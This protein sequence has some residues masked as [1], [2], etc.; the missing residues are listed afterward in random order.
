MLFYLCNFSPNATAYAHVNVALQFDENMY[1]ALASFGFT[2]VFAA[3]SLFAGAV[4][5]NHDR[6][7]LVGVACLGW[8]VATGLQSTATQFYQL[9]ILRSL[10]GAFQAFF[11]PCA[12]TLLA[13]LFP[14]RRLGAVNGVFSSAIYLGGSL[15][16]ISILL[17]QAL[18]WRSTLQIIAF[19]S[20]LVALLC[21]AA[22]PEPRY[23]IPPYS[24][25]SLCA[26]GV[27]ALSSLQV[28]LRTYE[29][30]LL[31]AA[32][33]FRWCAGYAIIV[34]KAPFVFA[35]FAGRD[36][37]FASS[38]AVVVAVGGLGSRSDPL[39]PSC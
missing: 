23:A 12:Y 15:A 24:Q 2:I 3:V 18:G 27:L 21:L 32:T 36:G 33:L 13:D 38:N 31:F 25:T 35:K 20:A 17:D 11:T 8:S 19:S 1:A 5:D 37:H 16:S 22:L 26:R 29:A 4:A 9:V 14:A 30:K 28:V 6:T 34:W 7:Y 10:V 39:W